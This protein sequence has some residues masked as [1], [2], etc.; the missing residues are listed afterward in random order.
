MHK[1]LSGVSCVIYI[2]SSKHEAKQQL[3]D[4]VEK[5]PT[6][7]PPSKYYN[8]TTEISIRKPYHNTMHC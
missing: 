4:Q 5:P 6:M 1:W 8:A 2:A 7:P 3:P